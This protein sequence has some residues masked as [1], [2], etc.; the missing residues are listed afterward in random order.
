VAGSAGGFV[1]PKP[2]GGSSS[3]GSSNTAL[4]GGGFVNPKPMGSGIGSSSS[5]F[6]AGGLTNSKPLGSSFGSSSSNFGSGGLPSSGGS[7]WGK[8]AAGAAGLGIGG[9]AL[10]GLAAK[11]FKK[12][13][14]GMSQ[15]S[16]F[17]KPKKSFGSYMFGSSKNKYGYKTPGY[18][19]AWGTKFSGGAGKYAK[20]G[21]S[22]K[23]LGLGVA[24]GFV[25]GAALGVAGTMATYSVYHKYQEFK[26]MMQMQQ[27]GFGSFN[28][29]YYNNYY[30]TNTC[31]GGCP[32]N[33]H[34]EWGFCECNAGSERRYGRCE[35]DWSNIPPRQASFDPFKTCSATSTCMAMDM[36]LVCNTDLTT[37]GNIGKCECRPD[38]KWNTQAGE[39]QFF[40]DVDCSSITYD[41]PPSKYVLSAVD[42]AQAQMA[43]PPQLSETADVIRTETMEES[44]TNS[45]LKQVDPKQ[46]TQADM[47]E[48]FCRDVD[49]YSFEFD[50]PKQ[51]TIVQRSGPVVA[52]TPVNI[53]KPPLCQDVPLSACAVMY[54]S[55]KCDSSGWKLIVPRGG[56]K[57]KFFSWYYK[58]RNDA[59]VIG[60]RAGCS[61]T[62]FSDSSFNGDRIIIAANRGYDR[63]TVLADEAEFSH[64][65][66]DIESV[67]C[68]CNS[69]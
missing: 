4:G 42:R 61:L 54:D 17:S 3:F 50:Q 20:K 15:Y 26:R 18:G 8:K 5:N 59:D 53:G 60:V 62:A 43:T 10:G 67:H 29:D 27:P 52:Q 64:M 16:S 41:T 30:L 12:N 48:A 68:T 11:G 58:Y 56:L 34:C 46:A 45:L 1:N 51:D 65:H 14:Y 38:M 25:G 7:G 2:L 9:A 37:S 55:H 28:N 66:E 22:K 44:L 32:L 33:S 6:G 36:N 24:A 13:P 21:I 40:L 23:A 31:L 39:C 57:F 19:T 69:F 49:A 63:W 47:R 35:N